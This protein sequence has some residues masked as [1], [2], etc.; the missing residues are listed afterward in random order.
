M[1]TRLPKISF[2]WQIILLGTVVVVLFIAVLIGTLG[3]LQYT[4]SAVL[5]TEKRRLLESAQDLARNYV[6]ESK[7]RNDK[8]AAADLSSHEEASRQLIKDI[9]TSS[10]QKLGGIEGGFYL[11]SGG[12]VLGYA[13]ATIQDDDQSH[14]NT[15]L[16]D[17]VQSSILETAKKASS[18]RITAE[19][20]LTQGNE[21]FLIEAVPVG[22]VSSEA[23]SAWTMERMQGVPGSNR[24]RAYLVTVALGV[25]ALVCVILTLLV[26]GNL[27]VTE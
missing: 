16:H 8:H 13:P 26:V 25:A 22:I 1:A 20:T 12:V 27:Q 7:I 19:M 18:T 23:G 5:N 9:S 6:D 21:I 2:R 14:V 15:A 17:E 4:K 24:L 10:L 3:A 11:V